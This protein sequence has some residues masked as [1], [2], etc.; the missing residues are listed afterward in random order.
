M[1]KYYNFQTAKEFTALRNSAKESKREKFQ[2]E[3]FSLLFQ[4]QH[5]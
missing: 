3:F 2:R 4:F 1:S 5:A